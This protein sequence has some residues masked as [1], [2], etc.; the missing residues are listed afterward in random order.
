MALFPVNPQLRSVCG[1]DQV[2]LQIQNLVK[3]L[4]TSDEILSMTN[5]RLKPLL[6]DLI[7]VTNESGITN[8]QYASRYGHAD[9]VRILLELGA[10]FN[11]KTPENHNALHL[12]VG[13]GHV[14]VAKLLLQ[15]GAFVNCK[16][17]KLRTPL[18]FAKTAEITEL[19][20]QNGADF[21]AKNEN[22]STP[23]ILAAVNGH[24]KVVEKLIQ[25]GADINA[26]NKSQDTALH[27]AADKGHFEI[28]ELLL[29]KGAKIVAANDGWTP[30]HAAAFKGFPKV[31]EILLK[32]GAKKDLVDKF[33]RTPLELA[34][35][36]KK[37]DYNEVIALL[38]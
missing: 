9:Q 22:K 13:Y 21:E 26:E 33:N 19:L 10:D 36:D 29:E 37:G 8:L 12:A 25:S 11:L 34:E 2:Y 7:D 5:Q 14:E 15:N 32:H 1:D 20:L 23:L 28:A 30:L 35:K 17:E 18:H 31:V 3:D 4:E 27:F 6:K 16:D 38:K 24:L